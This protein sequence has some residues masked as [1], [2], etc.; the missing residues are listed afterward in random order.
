[1]TLRRKSKEYGA[2]MIAPSTLLAS[3]LDFLTLKMFATFGYL[4][5]RFVGKDLEK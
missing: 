3:T 1:M 4:E 2:A 5:I